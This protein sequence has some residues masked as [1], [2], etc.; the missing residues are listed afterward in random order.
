MLSLELLDDV[1]GLLVLGYELEAVLYLA[2][3]LNHCALELSVH[4]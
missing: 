4:A 3:N 2:G 1:F